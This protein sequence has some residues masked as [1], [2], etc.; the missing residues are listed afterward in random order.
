MDK[1]PDTNTPGS[2]WKHPVVGA[3][4]ASARLLMTR[5][6]SLLTENGGHKEPP[7]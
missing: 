2:I 4:P 7:C 1:I 3:E 6:R 5:R